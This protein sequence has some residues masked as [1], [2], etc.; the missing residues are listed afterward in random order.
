RRI[1]PD[2]L[3][4]RVLAG[5]RTAHH[6]NVSLGQSGG[7]RE[8]AVRSLHAPNVSDPQNV[9]GALA[10]RRRGLD[11]HSGQTAG[12]AEVARQGTGLGG[13]L[14]ENG[15]GAAQ[16]V[17]VEPAIARIADEQLRAVTVRIARAAEYETP[18]VTRTE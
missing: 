7:E 15:I 11:Q 5:Q 18:A 1:A 13:A 10:I 16:P 17:G 12:E 8:E 4:Q 2:V 3:V 9:D 14:H 6:M